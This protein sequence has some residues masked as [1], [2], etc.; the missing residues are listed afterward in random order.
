VETFAQ[1]YDQV[2]RETDAGTSH[3]SDAA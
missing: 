2:A 3:S 1:S